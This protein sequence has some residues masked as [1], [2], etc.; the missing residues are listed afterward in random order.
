MFI[1][2]SQLELSQKHVLELWISYCGTL[3]IKIDFGG[4]TYLKVTIGRT[5]KEMEG[6]EIGCKAGGGWN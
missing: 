4:E 6:W 3:C 2:P 1:G 5:K